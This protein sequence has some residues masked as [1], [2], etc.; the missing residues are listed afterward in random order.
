MISIPVT[1]PDVEEFIGIKN[2][3]DKVTKANIS[4]RINDRFMAA[5]KNHEKYMLSFKREETGEIITK[6]VDAYELF[7]KLCEMNWNMAEP[8]ILFW[9]KINNWN[10][11]SNDSNFSYAGVNPCAEE[12]LPS[13]G[14]CLLGSINLAEFVKD[15]GQFDFDDFRR[16]INIAVIGLNEVLDEGLPLHPLK[17]QRDSV[18]QWR[19]IGLGIMGLADCLIKMQLRYG[20]NEAVYICNMIGHTMADQAL[21]TSA[22]LAKEY[23][24]YPMYDPDAVESSAWYSLNALGDT[25][26]L[27]HKYGLRNSQLLTSAPTGTLSTML[28]ISGGI[29][30]IFANYYE[31]KTESLVGHDKYYKVY[32]PIVQK[33]M[34]EHG[35]E[36]DTKLPDWFV[37]AHELKYENRVDM[38]AVWQKHIDASISSTIN[39]PNEATVEDIF[40]L[41]MLSWERGL[42]GVTI[43]RD[44]CA[45]TA[46][47]TTSKKEEESLSSNKSDYPDK[48]S[49]PRGVILKADD[50][51]IGKKRTLKTGCGTLHVEAFF[52]P[53]DGQLLETYFSR[54]SKGG[55]VNSYTG[56]SRMIS[57]AARGGIDIYSICDQLESCGACPSYAVRAATKHDT[58]K[59]ACCPSA[60]AKALM[61]M[62]E[63]MQEDILTIDD[64]EESTV[65]TVV[66]VNETTAVV[67][68]N[69]SIK[70]QELI[71]SGRCPICGEPLKHSGGCDFCPNDGWSHCG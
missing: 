50:N 55:C 7:Y 39:L 30:P 41:Y 35:L 20:S 36:D 64:P 70:Q 33:Y 43:F 27:V 12:P 31:R 22:L 3:L 13:G 45:R 44:G 24:A 9:D 23:G 57:L 54:G 69:D 28:G 34:D 18:A 11:L 40:N 68:Q 61:S 14:S 46:V 66:D 19:Q 51:C 5:V 26:D 25:K 42:K 67:N 65:N 8:G 2:D 56:L 38:Q 16:V 49:I 10:L 4:V 1:H 52:D 53:Y 58:S 17:E 6:E 29:E 71:D 21:R 15:D 60:I 63:E 48:D 47:L 37:T 32:T 59:G 62:Y